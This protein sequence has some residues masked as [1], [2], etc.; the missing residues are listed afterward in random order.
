MLELTQYGAQ[1]QE[2]VRATTAMPPHMRPRAVTSLSPSPHCRRRPKTLT[3]RPP[4]ENCSSGASRLCWLAPPPAHRLPTPTGPPKT[5]RPLGCRL[6]SSCAPHW[7]ALSPSWAPRR[8]PRASRRDCGCGMPAGWRRRW[9]SGRHLLLRLR[10]HR[11]GGTSRPQRRCHPAVGE[12]WCGCGCMET[13]LASPSP[14]H[15]I[16]PPCCKQVAALQRHAAP[17]AGHPA[18]KRRAAGA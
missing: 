11:R 5:P 13:R 16:H 15:F 17:A 2:G 10:R 9:T 12:P 4:Q 18:A 3:T 1:R 14:S 7:V 6:A 8:Q